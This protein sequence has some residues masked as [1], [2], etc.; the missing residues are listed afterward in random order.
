MQRPITHERAIT[1]RELVHER[2]W[3]PEMIKFFLKEYQDKF[4]NIVYKYD[5]VIKAEKHLANCKIG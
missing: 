3:N 2:N 5:D 4:G 1:E